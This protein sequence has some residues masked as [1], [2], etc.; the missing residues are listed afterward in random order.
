MFAES[1]RI[2]IQNLEKY[3]YAGE[4]SGHSPVE[5]LKIQIQAEYK[6]ISQ[7]KDFKKHRICMGTLN[8]PDRPADQ[9]QE[10]FPDESRLIRFI[11]TLKLIKRLFI[12]QY[13][14]LKNH[15]K[16]FKYFAESKVGNARKFSTPGNFISDAGI[17]HSYYRS[18]I[19]ALSK[20]EIHSV[21][22]IGG[23]FGGLCNL[24][25]RGSEIHT[26]YIVDLP[27]NLLLQHFYLHENGFRVY[28]WEKR[29]ARDEGLPCILLLNGV[30]VL[31]LDSEID[32]LINT[33]SMQHMSEKN[34]DFYFEQI[35]R[36]KIS[37]L[38]LVN[39]NTI[40]DNSDVKMEDYPIPASY[41]NIFLK[42]FYSRNHLEGI[43]HLK[44]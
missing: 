12:F 17:R 33:M 32:L 21:L 40:R 1:M 22:E 19:Q 2:L 28:P 43:Y 7:I 41:R 34:L 15:K 18:V 38:Y 8:E 37:S 11:N 5:N 20:R 13:F 3:D 14:S 9:S 26:Y 23:G 42:P 27:E 36:L 35:D 39:R 25:M 4:R 30:E 31:E 16:F 44:E 24:V 6:D 29:A 10:Y